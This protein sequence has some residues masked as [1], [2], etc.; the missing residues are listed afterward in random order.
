MSLESLYILPILLFS[1]VF[2]E[3]A[4][5][6]MA[7]RLGDPTAKALGRLTL[8]PIPHIDPI[9]SVLV[10]LASIFFTGRVFIA[11]AKP[12]PVNPMNFSN[13]RRDDFLVSVAGPVS[14]IIMA[15]F[16][17]VIAIIISRIFP[18]LRYGEVDTD[19]SSMVTN[20][21]AYLLMMFRGGIILNIGLAVFNLIP[22]PPLDGSHVLA[23]VLPDDLADRYENI[24]FYGIF[25]VMLLMNWQPFA[26]LVM[27]VVSVLAYPFLLMLQMFS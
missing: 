13:Y 11:W 2:H 19:S 27:T 14:N 9:G 10:P 3:L 26:S 21:F 6:W 17:T 22:V 23:S 20:V 1:V 4:H 15:F 24:G 16:C 25:I 12:V 5:G 7:L 18:E 8:N